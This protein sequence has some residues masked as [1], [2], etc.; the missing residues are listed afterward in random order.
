[1]NIRVI[2]KEQKG[3]EQKGSRLNFGQLSSWHTT[4]I[5]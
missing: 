2:L 4:L 1:M 5:F 3:S